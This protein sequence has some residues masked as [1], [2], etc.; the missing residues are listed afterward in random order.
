MKNVIFSDNII[1]I[2]FVAPFL[3]GV[4]RD[5]KLSKNFKLGEWYDATFMMPDEWFG[6]TEIPLHKNAIKV[7]QLVRDALGK[8]VEPTSSYRS[9]RWETEQRGRSGDSQHTKAFA[10]DLKG[11]GISQLI[12]EAI[13]QENE[14]YKQL[15]ALGVNGFGLYDLFAHLDFRP[16]KPNGGIY[17]WDNVKKKATKK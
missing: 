4:D 15:R 11:D 12:R 8:A 16:E 1:K 5:R 14:L 6:V 10:E 2:N 17:F 9:K 13:E 7:A 3:D